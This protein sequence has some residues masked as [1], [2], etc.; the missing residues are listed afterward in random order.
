MGA[1]ALTHALTSAASQDLSGFSVH[2]F[3]SL[4]APAGSMVHSKPP[5]CEHSS[6]APDRARG[7][8]PVTS[9]QAEILAQV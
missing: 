7:R 4:S 3:A 1:A 8:D 2:A 6:L 5:H 9:A